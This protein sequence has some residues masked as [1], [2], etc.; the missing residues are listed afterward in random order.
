MH[1]LNFNSCWEWTFFVVAAKKKR[2]WH[3]REFFFS[4]QNIEIWHW[5]VFYFSSSRLLLI[6]QTQTRTHTH[7]IARIHTR[8]QWAQ[9]IFQ[10]RLALPWSTGL[11]KWYPGDWD[12]CEMCS[13]TGCH[14]QSHYGWHIVQELKTEKSLRWSEASDQTITARNCCKTRINAK[15]WDGNAQIMKKHIWEGIPPA[16][17]VGKLL[18]FQQ[19]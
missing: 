2:I 12:A 6:T 5:A 3:F 17:G 13:V 14:G 19:S 7:T 18:C 11:I 15:Y 1:F 4:D 16:Y 10:Q 8:A 9:Q